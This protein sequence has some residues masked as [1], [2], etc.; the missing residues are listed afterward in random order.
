[1]GFLLSPRGC[2]RAS[3]PHTS[4]YGSYGSYLSSIYLLSYL[5]LSIYLIYLYLS[6][7]IYLF[8][9]IYLYIYLPHLYLSISISILSICLY[10][11]MVPDD[12]EMVVKNMF[13]VTA[14]V[15]IRLWTFHK[16]NVGEIPC[17]VV[18]SE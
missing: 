13:G 8:I 10:L 2:R 17:R 4:S 11:S 12:R 1:M 5:S 9:S 16:F 7:Y 6:I 3:R 14:G 18:R 15:I